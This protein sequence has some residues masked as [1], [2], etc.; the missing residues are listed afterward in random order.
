[1]EKI[2]LKRDTIK[3]LKK[4]MVDNEI[5]KYSHKIDKFE[6]KILDPMVL[7]Q[8]MPQL[9]VFLLVMGVIGAITKFRFESLRDASWEI[10]LVIFTIW[11]VWWV[12]KIVY[13]QKILKE[14]FVRVTETSKI[15]EDYYNSK[16]PR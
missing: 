13:S 7:G 8:K 16:E 5:N 10:P 2:K 6:I 1:M 11:I 12:V 14:T 15:K 9:I 3:D 4:F